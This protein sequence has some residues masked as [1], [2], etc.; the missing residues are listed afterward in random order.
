MRKT[1]ELLFRG[2][3]VGVGVTVAV[4]NAVPVAGT[5]VVRVSE[6][7]GVGVR[8]KSLNSFIELFSDNWGGEF[9]PTVSG[10]LRA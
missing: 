1:L 3:G 6:I 8:V 9:D 7:V 2:N 5:A 10:G 4:G